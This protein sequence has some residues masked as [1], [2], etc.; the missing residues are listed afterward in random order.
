MSYIEAV[1]GGVFNFDARIFGKDWDAEDTEIYDDLM[2][3]SKRKEEIYKALH[4]DQSTK[5]PIFEA[6]SGNVSRAYDIDSLVDYTKYYQHL[7][8]ERV[9]VI[10]MAGEFDM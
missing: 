10:I 2:L 7:I 8:D 4:V 5:V 6:I 1:S 9:P 3:K